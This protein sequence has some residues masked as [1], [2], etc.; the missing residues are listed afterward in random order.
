MTDSGYPRQTRL[1]HRGTPLS[2][3]ILLFE[4][5]AHD[6]SVSISRDHTPGFERNLLR[7]IITFRN[8]D[9]YLL[10][11]DASGAPQLDKVEIPKDARL[12][13]HREWL[14]IELRSDWTLG[15]HH[16]PPGSLLVALSDAWM[17]GERAVELLF[18]PSDRISLESYFFTR[19]YA[20]L[21]LLDNVR[22]RLLVASPPDTTRGQTRWVLAELPSISTFS[23]IAADPVD[24]EQS[25]DILLMMTDF[26]TP[27][28]MAL[29]SLGPNPPPPKV[30]K[31][32]PA[33]FDASPYE[34]TQNEAVSSDGT[35]IPYFQVSRRGIAADGS[36]PT[37]LYGYGGFEVSMTPSYSG[38]LG[39][40][41]L[42][43][44]GVYVLANLRGGGE[45]GPSWHQAALRENRHRSYEDFAAIAEH[46]VKRKIT[47]PRLL[48][49]MGGSN[50]GLLMG[51]VLVK[52]PY[53]FGAIVC[54][55]PLL[56]MRRYHRLLA[57]AS[58]VDEYGNPDDPEQWKFIQTFSP[59]HLL[60]TVPT[61]QSIDDEPQEAMSTPSVRLPP[62]LFYTSTK[63]DR[64]HPGHARKMVAKMLERGHR[65][66]FYYENIEGGHGGAANN[67]QRA[68]MNAL[69]WTFLWQHLR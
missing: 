63:D 4:G 31:S 23:S 52:Y 59:Y 17:R 37:L 51:N 29:Q 9:N 25:D 35:R 68:F 14:F 56:D 60:E 62:V 50:G 27:T 57:G 16:Y 1:W 15:D 32:S 40:I 24:A 43:L 48:G 53:L 41:W 7:H 34:I 36:H 8:V 18:S 45:F 2:E 64:V 42:E 10:T 21:S 26:L 13:F 44:G 65:Q 47:S 33:F 61:E 39:K 5:D 19:S 30:I 66:V 12:S 49:A 3:A 38:P 55:V 69:S 6:I 28:T 11:E 22:S 54:Q 67:S 58:W 20:V 46:L